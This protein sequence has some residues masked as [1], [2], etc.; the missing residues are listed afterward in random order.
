M[1]DVMG[2]VGLS[3]PRVSDDT[4]LSLPSPESDPADSPE[5][6]SL[7]TDARSPSGSSCGGTASDWDFL[8]STSKSPLSWD[9]CPVSAAAHLHLLGESLSLI[10]CHLQE[11]NVGVY[12]NYYFITSLFDME[13]S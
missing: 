2:A 5:G 4:Y 1:T 3:V 9:Q 13:C 7:I 10:G 11:T 6:P 12:S 8:R